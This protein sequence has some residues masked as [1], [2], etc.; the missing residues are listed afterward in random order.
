MPVFV[1]R[2]AR[3]AAAIAIGALGALGLTAPTAHAVSVLWRPTPNVWTD[4]NA[5]A[6]CR[7]LGQQNVASAGWDTYSCRADPSVSPSA[8]QLW[9]GIWVGCPT[10]TPL[11]QP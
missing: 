4:S 11:K 5:Q 9:I 10:C 2:Y 6:E 3:A 8:V 7:A 1:P